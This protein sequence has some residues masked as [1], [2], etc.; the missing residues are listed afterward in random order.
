M[1]SL[2]KK[3]FVVAIMVIWIISLCS[4]ESVADTY[5][6]GSWQFTL[7]MFMCFSPLA[8]FTWVGKKGWIDDIL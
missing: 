6:I 2:F 4:A 1:K 5:M 8:V 7:V 3:I